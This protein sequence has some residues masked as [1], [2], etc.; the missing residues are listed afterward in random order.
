MQSFTHSSYLPPG[1]FNVVCMTTEHYLG[2]MKH[3]YHV[4]QCS[5][6]SPDQ[7]QYEEEKTI[8]I[9]AEEI[10]W[11]YSPSRKWEKELQHLQGKKYG[12]TFHLKPG[13]V[14]SRVLHLFFFS[15]LHMCLCVH[16]LCICLVCLVH[17]ACMCVMGVSAGYVWGMHVLRMRSTTNKLHRVS[18]CHSFNYKCLQ[19]FLNICIA[20]FY[21]LFLPVFLFISC[22]RSSSGVLPVN[23]LMLRCHE[24]D[25]NYI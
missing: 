25:F 9:A 12:P 19:I 7:T 15:L 6:P 22:F 3:K 8:Y 23:L 10:V 13:R 16:A 4:R 18:V 24:C 14:H 17:L 20:Y 5:K 2:G 1:T 11:D 21:A